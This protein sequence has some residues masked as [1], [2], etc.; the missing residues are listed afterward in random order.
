MQYEIFGGSLPAVTMKLEANEKVFTQSGGMTW[1]TN[2]F[3]M[4]SNMRGGLG[5]AL[6]R[7]FSGESMFM[8]HYT[9]QSQGEITFASTFPGEIMALDITGRGIIAQKNAFLCAEDSV[10]LETKFTKKISAGLFGGEGFVLQR[11]SGDG[12]VFL[13]IAGSI[14]EKTLAPGEVFKVDTGNV[15]AFEESVQYNVETV[16]GV[17]N[18]LFGGEGLFLTVLTGPGKIW[19]QTMSVQELAN[20]LIPF[21]PLNNS[22]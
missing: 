17:K 14:Y 16:K 18:I 10:N 4:E 12:M 6:G 2:G 21:L 3:L 5:K 7:M 9:A 19:L 1:M 15:A 8:V 20:R 13:E 11:I 22:K